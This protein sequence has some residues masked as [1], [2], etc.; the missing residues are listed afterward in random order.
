MFFKND[1]AKSAARK[2]LCNNIFGFSSDG[3]FGTS[4]NFVN[5]IVGS[6]VIGMP[7]AFNQS[8]IGITFLLFFLVGVLT[9]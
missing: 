7:Y 9:G 4:F 2:Q 5:S 3:L 8:G 1:V 6:G